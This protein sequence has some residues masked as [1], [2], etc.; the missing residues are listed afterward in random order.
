VVAGQLNISIPTQIGY[1]YTVYYS[2]TLTSPNWQPVGLTIT[3]DGT[4]HVVTESMSG[5]QG[6]YKV[7]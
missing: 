3:G 4:T 1:N 7:E 6:Y 2:P 5:L